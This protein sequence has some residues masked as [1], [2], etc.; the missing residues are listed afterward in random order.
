[1]MRTMMNRTLVAAALFAAAFASAASPGLAQSTTVIVVRHAETTP[2]GSDPV[3][4][5]AGTTRARALAAAVRH[6]NVA[7]VYSTQYQRTRLT[8]GPIADSLHLTVTAMPA[9]NPMQAHID[10]IVA[11][12]K[13]HAG[14]TVVVVG[15]SNT[16]PMIIK[17]LGGPDIGAIP[18]TEY[19]N[20]FT[21]IS[22][23]TGVR[24]I[25]SRY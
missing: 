14:K 20:L 3:L 23:S 12:V 19:D 4:S 18:E 9:A 17:A 13:E 15:H 8:A 6:A 21:V 2:G 16:V 5:E 22:D 24:L 25:R 7:A 11:K 10:A 1:M